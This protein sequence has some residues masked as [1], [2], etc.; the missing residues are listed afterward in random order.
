MRARSRDEQQHDQMRASSACT[1]SRW[2]AWK[3]DL[4][5][6]TLNS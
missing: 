3:G 1:T 2:I 5:L 4:Y 6:T